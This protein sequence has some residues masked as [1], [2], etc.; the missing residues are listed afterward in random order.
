MF[1]RLQDKIV[2]ITGASA[3]IGEACARHYAKHGSKL[4]LIA[5]RVERL[6]LLKTELESKFGTEIL[7]LQADVRK[8]EDVAALPA[9]IPPEMSEIDILVN[10]AGLALGVEHTAD[11]SLENLDGM[12]DTNVKGVMYMLKTFLPGMKARKR[13][14]IVMISSVAG[15]WPYA[16]GSV[17]CATKAA[18]DAITFS[19]RTE[20]VSTPLR[21]FSIAPGMVNTEFS[22]VRL[23]SKEKADKVYENMDVLS[24]DDI[25]EYI[26]LATSRPAHVV[27]TDLCIV[28]SCQASCYAVHRG[29]LQ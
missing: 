16:G 23:G 18:L 11:V 1:E 7:T 10:N 3:G 26:T 9:Q 19:L 17:Y 27:W 6:A 24:A 28:P 12:V 4:I 22:T 8:Y 15:R 20:L 14:D 25:A 2:M 13:G 21:V 5:R 29:P